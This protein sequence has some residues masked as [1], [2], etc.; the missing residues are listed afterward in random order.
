MNRRFPYISLLKTLAMLM[1]V[2][3]H[4]SLYFVNFNPFWPLKANAPDAV[5]DAMVWLF[6]VFSWHPAFC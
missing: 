5:V 2:L 4:S 1:V 6:P 3:L